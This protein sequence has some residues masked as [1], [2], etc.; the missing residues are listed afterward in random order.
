MNSFY[1]FTFLLFS[2]CFVFTAEPDPVFAKNGMVVSTSRH[3]S[4]AGIKILKNGGNAVD[5]AAAV[6]F[7]LAVTSSSN[8]NIGGGGFMVARFARGKTFTLDFRETAPLASFNNMFLD[9]QGNP[10]KDASKYTRLAA[11]VPGSVSGL[12]KAWQDFGSGNISRNELLATAIYLAEKGFILSRHEAERFNANQDIFRRNEAAAE[13]FIRRDG[14]PWESGDRFIQSDLAKT[15]KR[16]AKEGQDGFY[17]GRTADLLVAEMKLGQGLISH[18]DLKNYESKYR[19]PVTGTFKDYEIISMGPPSSGGVLLINMLNMLE[20]FELEKIGWNSAD[21]IHLLTEVERRAYAD[22]AQH[23]G[24][25]DYWKVPLKM[26]MSKKYARERA[27]T[28]SMETA[29]PSSE[30]FAGDPYPYESFETT[31]Y[32]IVDKEGNAVSVSTTLNLSYGGG[33][34]VKGAGFFLNNEMDDFSI[35]PGLP[36]AFG[37]IGNEANAIQP[38]K[39]PLSSMTPTIVL[40]EEIPFFIIGSPGGA[41]IITTTL[42]CILNVAIFGMDAAAAVSSPRFHSQW[43]PDIIKSEPR[44]INKNTIESLKKRGHTLLPETWGYLGQANGIMINE[45][46]YW[47]AGDTRGE[48]SSKGY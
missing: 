29:T 2:T 39:R 38:G 46:G 7:V 8:G 31:H 26:L 4:E 18:A 5:A 9:E 23:L 45:A 30:V 27:S 33:Y 35:K 16:I 42:Q 11:G 48:T 17:R 36:N 13:V 20:N 1:K 12:L 6:G 32:S 44:A 22:R 37:L 24:D 3:A 28:I 14:R 41:T 43:L 19:V 25:L 21:Y 10:V 15:L 40:K 34:F 47:G